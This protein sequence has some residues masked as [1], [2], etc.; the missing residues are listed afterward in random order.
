MSEDPLTVTLLGL[1]ITTPVTPA[2]VCVEIVT[3]VIVI[4][5]LFLKY[6]ETLN[7][8]VVFPLPCLVVLGL[9]AE[10]LT[11]TTFWMVTS[12]MSTNFQPTSSPTQM[13]REVSF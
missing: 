2:G 9:R 6:S 5:T 3:F 7:S 1:Y 13:M 10:Q 11:N 8:Y 4:V 12:F